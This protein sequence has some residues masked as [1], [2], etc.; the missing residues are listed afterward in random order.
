MPFARGLQQCFLPPKSAQQKLHK[1]TLQNRGAQVV[2][3]QFPGFVDKEEIHDRVPPVCFMAQ[4]LSLKN[5]FEGLRR[6][7]VATSNVATVSGLT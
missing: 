6:I 5:K 3:G 7:S 1:H 4:L 2:I